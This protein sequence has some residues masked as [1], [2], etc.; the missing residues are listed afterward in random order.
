MDRNLIKALIAA[1][2]V[3]FAIAACSS[4]VNQDNFDKIKTGMTEDEVKNILGP[5]TETSS[6]SIAGFSGTSSKWESKN[7][8][9]VIQFFNGE[10]QIK[11][12]SNLKETSP[13]PSVK[14]KKE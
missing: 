14:P 10:V 5:P 8:T 1:I 6:M 3:S 13:K 7:G 12:F 11:E 2:M 4:K 9:I